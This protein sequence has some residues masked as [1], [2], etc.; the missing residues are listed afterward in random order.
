MAGSAKQAKGSLRDTAGK[1]TGDSNLQAE[2]K[3]DKAQGKIQNAGG[4]VKD[5]AK[6]TDTSVRLTLRWQGKRNCWPARFIPAHSG[7][8]ANYAIVHF[9]DCPTGF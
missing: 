6:R 1:A 7:A 5:T 4:G 3:A 9:R 2:G 8:P